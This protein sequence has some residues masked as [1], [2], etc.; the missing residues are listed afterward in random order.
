MVVTQHNLM[1]PDFLGAISAAIEGGARLIQLRE[2]EITRDELFD[3][4]RAAKEICIARGARLLVNADL[5]IARKMGM[6]LHLP[7]AQSVAQARR[8][9]GR[10]YFV[11]QSV[12][13]LSS[14]LRA[15][16]SGANYVV[17]GSIFPTASHVGSAPKGVAALREIAREISI[18]VF[19]IGGISQQ[20]CVQCLEAGAHG[21]AVMRAVWQ[22][23]NTKEAVAKFN[24]VLK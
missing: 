18:P 24:A 22:A 17:F 12:H 9:L 10:E 4:A 13:S 20:N 23:E 7:E 3:F 21:V 2:K 11:G 16:K 5:E 1:H 19:A 8:T 14:A 15:Q 6:G